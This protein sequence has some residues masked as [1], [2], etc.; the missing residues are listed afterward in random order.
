M[1]KANQ[2][3]VTEPKTLQQILEDK[4]KE[5]QS[6]KKSHS[7]TNNKLN[8][9]IALLSQNNVKVDAGVTPEALHKQKL[10]Q[11]EKNR[12]KNAVVVEQY[13]KLYPDYKH[14]KGSKVCLCKR[15][16]NGN[17]HSAYLGRSKLIEDIIAD[18]KKKGLKI[19]S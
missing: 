14:P 6:L 11:E 18:Y 8:E 15:M 13:L 16:K 1:S 19:V 10:I 3:E 9:L 12:R 17:V 4:D 7:E 5:I 2:A